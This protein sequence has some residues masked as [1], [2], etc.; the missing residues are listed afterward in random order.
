MGI[1]PASYTAPA[2]ERVALTLRRP[3]SE[4]HRL[5]VVD[6]RLQLELDGER[7]R[8][9][10]DL[11][12]VAQ[13]APLHVTEREAQAL[14]LDHAAEHGRRPRLDLREPFERVGELRS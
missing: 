14:G 6:D 10:A 7:P 1:T 8:P 5:A 4:R 9:A 3:G 11:V 13:V 12:P 2:V